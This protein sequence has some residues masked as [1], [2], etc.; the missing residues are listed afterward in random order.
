MNR[1]FRT[2]TSSKK[3]KKNFCSWRIERLVGWILFFFFSVSP[4]SVSDRLISGPGT[5]PSLLRQGLGLGLEL[6]L[7]LG[8]GLG[9]IIPIFG[10]AKRYK[11]F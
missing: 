10:I 7:G 6:E 3:K 2:F 8:L 4:V 5:I 1:I 9:R 11:N